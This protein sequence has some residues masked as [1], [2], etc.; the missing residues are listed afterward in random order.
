MQPENVSVPLDS[1][2]GGAAE[3]ISKL[4]PVQVPRRPPVILPVGLV[5]SGKI[6]RPET[7]Y[8]FA[9]AGTTPS[10]ITATASIPIKT[11][12]L[13][14]VPIPTPIRAG[15]TQRLSHRRLGGCKGRATL[16]A[17]IVVAVGPAPTAPARIP[18]LPRPTGAVS[19]TV[20]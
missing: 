5:G 20:Q 14:R 6:W 15:C 11:E 9:A 1:F 13:R 4:V 2:N 7:R 10:A 12:P 3:V 16:A 18:V 17:V 19:G 8:V